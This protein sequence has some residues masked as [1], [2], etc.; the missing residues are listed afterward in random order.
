[1][2]SLRAKKVLE[3]LK[4]E[5]E[6]CRLQAD[7]REQV[8][9]SSTHSLQCTTSLHVA[10]RFLYAELYLTDSLSTQQYVPCIQQVVCASPTCEV[11]C[12]ATSQVSI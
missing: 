4:K 5:V 1:M 6:L 9:N 3:L 10:W 12:R 2:C 8:S 11:C 7:I